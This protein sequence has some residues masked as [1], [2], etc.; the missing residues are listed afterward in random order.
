MDALADNVAFLK[1]P[2]IGCKYFLASQCHPDLFDVCEGRD[3]TIFHVYS[4]KKE[5]P[6][7]K[8][9]YGGNVLEVVGSNTIATRSI[10]LCRMLGWQKIHIFGF[11]SCLMDG[12]HHSYEQAWNDQD[13]LHRIWCGGREFA[14]APWH[15]HQYEGWMKFARKCGGDFNLQVHGN[16][17]IAHMMKTGATPEEK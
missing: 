7:L 6:L 10:W 9:F 3:L 4:T 14:C 1:E 15:I 8:K 5:R 13:D 17:L 11:D 2:I 12:E 16:G